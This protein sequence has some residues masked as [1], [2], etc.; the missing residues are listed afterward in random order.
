[1]N[2]NTD[3]YARIKDIVNYLGDEI[4]SYLLTI[5]AITGCDTTS[6]FFNNGKVKALQK[7]Q[8][9]LS[10]LSLVRNIDV[11]RIL[12]GH[13]IGCAMDLV[14]KVVYTGKTKE[15][16]IQTRIRLY[17]SS[18]PKSTTMIPPDPDSLLQ[19]IKR[20]HYQVFIWL[21]SHEENMNSLRYQEFGVTRETWRGLFGL[22]DCKFHQS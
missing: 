10:F 11:E 21:R 7:I 20:V 17:K 19:A 6:A 9:K 5:H 1:M 3:K 22:Q 2:Y 4:S 14:R 12:D 18:T 8:Q 16:Y 15:N 13:T